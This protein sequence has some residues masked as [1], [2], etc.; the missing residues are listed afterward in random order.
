M[1][2]YLERNDRVSSYPSV[3]Y[4][5]YPWIPRQ[6]PTAPRCLKC[7]YNVILILEKHEQDLF[8]NIEC[9][10]IR[11][12]SY[13]FYSYKMYYFYFDTEQTGKYLNVALANAFSVLS[14]TTKLYCQLLFIVTSWFW[15]IE[16]DI[17]Q[18]FPKGS[19]LTDHWDLLSHRPRSPQSSLILMSRNI[20]LLLQYVL[21]FLTIRYSII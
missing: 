17:F 7:L 12:C 8:E 5:P 11:H 4:L 19:P 3:R 16:G 21:L 13:V 18:F 15:N 9:E 10:T 14:F 1:F 2:L 20:I 6:D